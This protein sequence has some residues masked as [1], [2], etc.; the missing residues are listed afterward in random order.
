MVTVRV[1]LRVGSAV[2]PEIAWVQTIP[3]TLPPG[4]PVSASNR[5]LG[6]EDS[7]FEEDE[8]DYDEE[9]AGE[10]AGTI[11]QSGLL[12]SGTYYFTVEVLD[13]AGQLVPGASAVH[14]LWVSNPSRVDL[15]GP[16]GLFGGHLPVIATSTP[17]FFWSTDALADVILPSGRVSA[18]F[19]IRVVKVEGAPT[20]EEAMQGFAVWEETVENQTTV[21]Y[22]SSVEAMAL[23]LG[24]T[25]AW[26]VVRQV[27]TSGGIRG[28]ES[29]I[30][31][32]KMEDPTGG[33]I[34]SG[35]EEA[36]AQMLEQILELHGVAGEVE[37]YQPTG[38][39]LIDGRPVDLN[40][41]RNLLEQV[42]SGQLQIAT[43]IIR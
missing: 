32:F 3:I 14:A 40:S 7:P 22:P 26:Q 6:R 30:F 13:E 35:I 4:E 9:A 25:Y 12:P 17:Q 21:V 10:L 36:V 2:G 20:A 15:V 37:G 28:I 29:D 42:L 41:L 31:W 34:G 19:Q 27:E 23:E 24:E 43:I 5:E 33:L 38:Q 1:S 39:V 8:S 11:L 16:G 18:G